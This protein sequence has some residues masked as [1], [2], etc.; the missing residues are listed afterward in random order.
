M[1][2]VATDTP[3]PAYGIVS[4]AV[5]EDGL[6]L[7][8]ARWL[9]DSSRL[10]PGGVRGTVLVLTGRTEFIEKYFEVVDDLRRRGFAV[11]VFDWRGQ[12][13]SMRLLRNRRKGHVGAFS[14][15]DRDIDAVLQQVV[16]PFCP[17][18]VYALA[19][20]MGG[21]IALHYARRRPG[22]FP[23]LV[24]SAPL[25]EIFGLPAPRGLRLLART[26]RQAGLG[27]SYIPGGS[28]RS[29]FLAPF[30]SNRLTSDPV[31]WARMVAFARAEPAL[32]LGAP[33]IAWIDGA[34]SA[35]EALATPEFQTGLQTPTLFVTAGLDR[36][37]D[38][39]AAEHLSQRLR[40]SHTIR[41]AQ[42]RHE[43]LMET[44]DLRGRF[45]AAFDAFV[46]GSDA[47]DLLQAT[48]GR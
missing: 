48:I 7:R 39:R 43:V 27:R 15:Y 26:L 28:D 33:T 18:P 5:T 4:P 20:S 36:I 42:A 10:P 11:V 25:V 31:R 38:S 29:E 24:L 12:G 22:V 16:V 46:P 9:P 41:I 1:D 14:D 40:A 19:H 17:E 34:F 8:T 13:L 47:S 45:W 32:L 2:L 3:P 44:D 21:T 37:V 23:R 35:M 6:V 30:E